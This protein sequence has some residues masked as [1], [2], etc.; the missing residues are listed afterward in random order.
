MRT[1]AVIAVIFAGAVA[2]RW[3]GHRVTHGR[4]T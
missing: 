2:G 3:L 1:L 4:R